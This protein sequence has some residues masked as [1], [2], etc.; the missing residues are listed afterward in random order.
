MPDAN[1]PLSSEVSFEAA[2]TENGI[3]AAAKSRFVAA[4]D[5]LFGGLLDI[6]GSFVEGK[7]QR[8]RLEDE[9][10]R[11]RIA[12]RAELELESASALQRLESA[13]AYAAREE[14]LRRLINKASVVAEALEDFR[15]EVDPTEEQ[16]EVEDDWLNIF[17]D[18]ASRASSDRLRSL[19]G[20]I[21]AGEIR[22]PGS[23]SL[24]TLRILSEVDQKTA[25]LFQRYVVGVLQGNLLIRPSELKG[26]ALMDLTALEE[27]GL[28]QE[29]SG[30]IGI[31]HKFDNKGDYVFVDK[32]FALIA[33]GKPGST[34]RI[35]VIKIS[36]AGEEIRRIVP[37]EAEDAAIRAVAEIVRKKADSLELA[38]VTARPSANQISYQTLEK[39][40]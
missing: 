17:E 1:D 30:T 31:D 32:N 24:T 29:A 28:L 20:K 16:G 12:R 6:P 11:Q 23:F 34:V 19:W 40:K 25:E 27:A 38:K 14:Q 5:R 26:Q 33:K 10:E 36:R 2:L 7:A 35:S 15:E 4:A 9:I 21:L 39:L 8:R 37:P 13:A 18:H 22:R 3:K